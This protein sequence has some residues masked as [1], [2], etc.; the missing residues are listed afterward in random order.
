LLLMPRLSPSRRTTVPGHVSRLSLPHGCFNAALEQLPLGGY[1]CVYRRDE[2]RFVVCRLDAHLDVVPDS[3]TLLDLGPAPVADPRLI[4]LPDGRLFMV[5]SSLDTSDGVTVECMRGA[6]LIENEKLIS[7]PEP[8]LLS[9]KNSRARQKNWMP[10]TIGEANTVYLIAS[11]CPHVVFSMDCQTFK[12]EQ[13]SVW[14]WTHCWE[15][16]GEFLRGNTQAVQIA[17]NLMLGTFHTGVRE[18]PRGCVFYDNG[19]FLF[20]SRPPFKVLKCSDRS[21][22]PAEM[23]TEKHFRKVDQILCVFPCGMVREGERLL[24]S[25]GNNDSCVNMLDTTVKAMLETMVDTYDF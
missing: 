20:E 21:Y 23:A 24:I 12:T 14:Q 3:H 5:Y 13:V 22:I 4:W 7:K 25:F 1:I 8:H 19:C 18:Q 10:F 16:R 11:V 17:E 2:Y 15:P 9:P 6:V